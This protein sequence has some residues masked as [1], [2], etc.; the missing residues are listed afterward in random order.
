[1]PVLISLLR[2][3]NLGGHRKVKMEDLRALYESLG[4]D[5]VQTYINSGNVLFKTQARDL[6]RLRKKIEDAIEGACGFRCDVILRTPR[7]L[8]GVIARDPFAAKSGMD[9]R[10]YAVHFLIA[11]PAAAAREKALAID[12]APEE[13]HVEGRELYIYYHNGMARPRL[14]LAAVERILESSGTTRNW[15]TVRKLLELAEK[16]EPPA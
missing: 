12:I 8:R 9:P 14:S 5:E 3:V 11:E 13:L 15:N 1:M 10:K 6:V 2:G 7:D 16:L 4:F